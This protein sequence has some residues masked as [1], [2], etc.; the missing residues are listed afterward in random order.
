MVVCTEQF[1]AAP[2]VVSRNIPVQDRANC[3]NNTL[4][5]F[6]EKH[7]YFWLWQEY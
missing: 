5:L 1:F 4:F 7:F 3:K 2:H 6:S